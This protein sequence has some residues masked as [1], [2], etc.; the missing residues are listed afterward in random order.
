M[1]ASSMSKAM[2]SLPSGATPLEPAELNLDA[3]NTVICVTSDG[4][5]LAFDRDTRKVCNLL[6]QAGQLIKQHTLTAVRF[7]DK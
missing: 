1:A 7:A 2:I 4:Y 6:A 3:S 5:M